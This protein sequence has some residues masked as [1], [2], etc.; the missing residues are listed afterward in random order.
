MEASLWKCGA[1]IKILI[2]FEEF[3]KNIE[4]FSW[5]ASLSKYILSEI[6]AFLNI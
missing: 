3:F 4:G 5:I 2:I 1:F 6:E